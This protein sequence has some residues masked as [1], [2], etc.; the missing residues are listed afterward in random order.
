MNFKKLGLI[1]TLVA[2]GVTST[3]AQE[4]KVNALLIAWYTQMMD[5]NLRNNGAQNV[6]SNYYGLDSR[7]T[8]NTFNVRRAEIYCN[9]KIND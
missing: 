2:A 9:Y 7:F 6:V 5:S 1:A 8:E 3:Q 4:V